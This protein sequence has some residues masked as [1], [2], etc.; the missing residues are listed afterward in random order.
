MA[1]KTID[2]EKVRTNPPVW[3]D[4]LEAAVYL[5]FSKATFDKVIRFYIPRVKQ[6]KRYVYNRADLDKYMASMKI[7]PVKELPNRKSA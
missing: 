7:K 5:N 1:F 2:K 3:M 6:G 4:S